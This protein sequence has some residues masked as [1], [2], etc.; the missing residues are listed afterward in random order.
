MYINKLFNKE[1]NDIINK[2]S[3]VWE[4]PV[5]PPHGRVRAAADDVHRAGAA[6]SIIA[7]MIEATIT[8]TT[9]VKNQ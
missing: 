9:S 5:R 7:S 3:A 1:T 6:I 4:G 2:T 8:I